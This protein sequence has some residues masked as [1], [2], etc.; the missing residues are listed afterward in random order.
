MLAGLV[1]QVVMVEG[2]VHV[3][4]VTTRIRN[5]WALQRTG[6]RIQTAVARAIDAS[7]AAGRVMRDRSFLSVPGQTVVA[8][9]RSFTTSA[10]L[11]RP[12]MLP[13]TEVRVAIREIV[14]TSFDATSDEIVQA[15]ARLLG[16]RTREGQIKE[17]IAGQIE[18]LK[19][20]GTLVSQGVML[21]LSQWRQNGS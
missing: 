2:P 17:L 8:R 18:V 12:E 6:S 9:D 13:P 21:V 3:D 5:A 20:E 15:V 11:R 16:F 14:E 4:E 10:A 19:G 1:D 7:C